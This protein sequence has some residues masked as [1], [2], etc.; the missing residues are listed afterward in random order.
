MSPELD[1]CK[2]FNC[3]CSGHKQVVSPDRHCWQGT[4]HHNWLRIWLAPPVSAHTKLETDY[5]NFNLKQ[6]SAQSVSS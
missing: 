5:W 6:A 3:S 1:T 4:E 2:F